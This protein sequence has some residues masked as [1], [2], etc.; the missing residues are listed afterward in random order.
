MQAPYKA[1]AKLSAT[2][3]IASAIT[4]GHRQLLPDTTGDV[5]LA[6]DA[7]TVSST[8][9]PRVG[10]LLDACTRSLATDGEVAAPSL[11]AAVHR[12]GQLTVATGPIQQSGI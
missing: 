10:L 11:D 6:G 2:R 8:K 7:L 9:P 3:Q 5:G 1:S 4:S 12:D